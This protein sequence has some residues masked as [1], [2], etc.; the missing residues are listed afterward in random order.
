MTSP[1]PQIQILEKA[2]YTKQHL[3][4][5]HDAYPLPRLAAGQI[6]IRSRII[7]STTNN[8]TYARLG[9][10]LGWWDVW[11]AVPSL[12]A[13]YND[14]SKY[15]RVSAW[16]YCEV[17]ESQN[18]KVPVG[19][20]LYGYLPIGDYPETLQV[21][22]EDETGHVLE[23]KTDLMAD[24][25]SRGLDSVMLPFFETSYLLNRYT[26]AWEP[27]KRTHPLGLPLPWSS[28][29]A[30][31]ANA[32]VV[33]LGASGKTALSFAYQLRQ[34]RPV[35]QQP[36]KVAA[37]GSAASR[38]FTEGTGLF[39]EVM[40]YAD[41]PSITDGHIAA[42]LGLDADTKVVL[43]NFAGRGTIDEDLHNI[44]VRVCKRVNVLLVGGDPQGGGSKLGALTEV[45]G[46]NV[47]LCNASGLR[48]AAMEIDKTAPYF[49]NF[50]RE[51]RRF[52]ETGAVKGFKLR[53]GKGMEEYTQGWDSLCNGSVDPTL[54]LV[55]EI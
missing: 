30:D 2:D 33:M 40:L 52:K 31:L 20:K 26:F 37:V 13:P 54:G 34:S 4:T 24:K 50:Q 8:F 17:T 7:S 5:L 39:D 21:A 11:A 23:T 19:T 14:A 16:G 28:D 43:V 32:V 41:A 18:D 6:R 25:P 51:W 15:G 9:H 22:V 48:D 1:A 44:F 36:R 47:V 35:E 49:E 27:E 10:L 55:Y 46:S 45:P 42:R 38:S 3:V 53:W 29:D 12:P